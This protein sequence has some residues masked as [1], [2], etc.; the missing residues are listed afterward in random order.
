MDGES[1][2]SID[3]DTMVQAQVPPRLITVFAL[4][5]T[6]PERL[7]GPLAREATEALAQ[8][9]SSFEGLFARSHHLFGE[10]PEVLDSTLEAPEELWD[11][12][13]RFV[14]MSS[15]PAGPML[16]DL[17]LEQGSTLALTGRLDPGREEVALALNL[18]DVRVPNLLWCHTAPHPRENLPG[19]LAVLA[20]QIAW[21]LEATPSYEEA[22]H[23]TEASFGTH[24]AS[25]WEAFGSA[26]DRLRRAGPDAP[27]SLHVAV[28]RALCQALAL[29]PNYQA[30]R[31]LLLE[32]A[33]DRL[34]RADKKSAD[35]LLRGLEDLGSD[36]LMYDLLAMEAMGC[37][38]QNLQALALAQ[39]LAERFPDDLRVET[40][41]ARAKSFT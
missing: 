1:A 10:A 26:R 29:D 4:G 28:I 15:M 5:S 2:S 32:Q 34:R 27:D 33:S 21:S 9:L 35:A 25:A 6:W 12:E 18:W 36:H 40:W 3:S 17:T 16:R 11:P 20:A 14:L 24:D 39:E 19:E 30:A 22:L 38:G 7:A 23:I 37:L 41:I 31:H 13:A 8:A